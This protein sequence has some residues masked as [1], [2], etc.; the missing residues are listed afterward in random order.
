[1]NRTLVI[2]NLKTIYPQEGYVKY[3]KQLNKI[4]KNK[5]KVLCVCVPFVCA[6]IAKKIL[7]N[8]N[9]LISFQNVA[10]NSVATNTGE[11]TARMLKEVGADCCLVCHKERRQNFNEDYDLANLKIKELLSQNIFPILCVGENEQELKKRKSLAVIEKQLE[12]ALKDVSLQNAKN[13]TIV[14]EP[15]IEGGPENSLA[16]TDLSVIGEGIKNFISDLYRIK[17]YNFKVVFGG[18]INENNFS[19]FL[20]LKNFDGIILGRNSVNVAL[21]QS[22]FDA[23]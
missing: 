18:N 5:N 22:I 1:M 7:K 3:F 16:L 9:I 19:N 15:P 11:I 4:V 8:K 17:S 6:T 12:K 10:E 23:E 13:I 14:Y 2:A 21:L 20:R